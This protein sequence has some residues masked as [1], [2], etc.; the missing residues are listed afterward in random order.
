MQFYEGPAAPRS[1]AVDTGEPAGFDGGTLIFYIL[2]VDTFDFYDEAQEGG[3][4]VVDEDM[5]SGR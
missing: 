3:A 4:A 1:E 2:A 5:K